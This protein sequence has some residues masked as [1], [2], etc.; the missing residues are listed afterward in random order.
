MHPSF[1]DNDIWTYSTRAFLWGNHSLIGQPKHK[2]RSSKFNSEP[3]NGGGSTI[4]HVS[5]FFGYLSL[6]LH[7]CHLPIPNKHQGISLPL[8]AFK[9]DDAA[10]LHLPF[11]FLEYKMS[12]SEEYTLTIDCGG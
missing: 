1:C 5:D 2:F 4:V 8:K 3:A 10:T 11:L 6:K 9:G 12:F 7:A